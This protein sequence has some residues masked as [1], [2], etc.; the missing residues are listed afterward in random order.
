MTTRARA[1][2]STALMPPQLMP[3]VRWESPDVF[4]ET[5]MGI[6]VSGSSFEREQSNA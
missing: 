2:S 3:V 4:S 6:G 1:R 5:T